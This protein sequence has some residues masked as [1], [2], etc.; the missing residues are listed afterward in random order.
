VT[1]WRTLARHAEEYFGP[2][3]STGADMLRE[4]HAAAFAELFQRCRNTV[5]RG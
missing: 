1:R 5:P 4:G 3:S 2:E